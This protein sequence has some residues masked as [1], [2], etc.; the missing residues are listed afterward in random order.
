YEEQIATMSDHLASLNERLT[1]QNDE[2]DRLQHRPTASKD[3]KK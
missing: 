1:M 3:S 2:I